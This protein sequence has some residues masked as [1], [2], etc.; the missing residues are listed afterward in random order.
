MDLNIKKNTNFLTNR[1]KNSGLKKE[2]EFHGLKNIQKLKTLNTARMKL[3]S[4]GIMME[5]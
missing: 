3:R 1:M 2:K 5:L 4:N